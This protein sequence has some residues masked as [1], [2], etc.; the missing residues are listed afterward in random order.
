MKNHFKSIQ[1]WLWLSFVTI[2][3]ITSS[4][5]LKAQVEFFLDGPVKQLI[6]DEPQP[7]GLSMVGQI[8]L[9]TVNPTNDFYFMNIFLFVPG[10]DTIIWIGQNIL[11][12]PD[13]L[14]LGPGQPYILTFIEFD[15]DPLNIFPPDLPPLLSQIDLAIPPPAI[16]PFLEPIPIPSPS[17]FQPWPVELFS[18]HI[19]PNPVFPEIDFDPL[20]PLNFPPDLSFINWQPPVLAPPT[21]VA[22]GCNVPNI[23]LAYVD[24]GPTATYAGD[25]NAC[26]PAGTANSFMWLRDQHDEIDAILELVHGQGDTAHRKAL[27]DIS[28]K[29]NRANNS[30]VTSRD[31][32]K[33]KQTFV[34]CHKLPVKVK[35]QS[36]IYDT[37]ILSG[38]DKYGHA[39]DNQNTD[40]K[41]VDPCW[42]VMELED[43]EDV[44]LNYECYWVDSIGR[45][46]PDDPATPNV[47][48]SIT[49]KHCVALT[50][51][52]K[53]PLP[54]TE[55]VGL[56][57]KHDLRQ[58]S[59][60]GTMMEWS[61]LA[62]MTINGKEYVELTG[63]SG[64][65]IVSG[66]ITYTRR[67]IVVDAMSESF[68]DTVTFDSIPCPSLLTIADDTICT[69]VYK[70]DTICLNNV[71]I[72][73]GQDVLFKCRVL[74][75]EANI[76]QQTPVSTWRTDENGCP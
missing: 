15:L 2:F 70:A 55:A 66:G 65:R 53:I 68:D 34:D 35:Y 9:A 73:G 10:P 11:I 45:I 72:K 48:E 6:F 7:S 71:V 49:N 52:Y 25:R 67:C 57:F 74:K 32:A 27:E 56:Q 28:M 19:L 23:D 40:S 63:K 29:M 47:N 41:T 44:E 13:I 16:Q 42:I 22:R 38:E 36:I 33:G 18:Q 24:H 20:L 51:G 50:G 76:T 3:L 58:D 59:V 61:G 21:F 62:P 5:S 4:S 60:G 54:G 64:R 39:A 8:P 14:A 12:P 26:V 75:G 46:R 1:R 31:H 37:D 17:Q 30:G 43:G 69:G